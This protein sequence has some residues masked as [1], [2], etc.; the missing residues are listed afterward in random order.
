V[1]SEDD[2]R[3]RA[4]QAFVAGDFKGAVKIAEAFLE[5]RGRGTVSVGSLM[6]MGGP[7]QA[8]DLAQVAHVKPT[9]L[10]TLP[11]HVLEELRLEVAVEQLFCH[12]DKREW[13]PEQSGYVRFKIQF[14]KNM[15]W[16]AAVRLADIEGY[17]AIGVRQVRL[18]CGGMNWPNSAPEYSCVECRPLHETTYPVDCLP[19]L[20]HPKCI[21][22]YG[23]RCRFTPVSIPG[24]SR[25]WR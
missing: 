18:V 5:S 1:I 22:Y 17:K 15:L 2:D 24:L 11:K 10:S 3:K 16:F 6:K 9:I 7:A 4:L 21:G 20:P 12:Q 14:A 23:C 8:R 25:K 13:P 19:E